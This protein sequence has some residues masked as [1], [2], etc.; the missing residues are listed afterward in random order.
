M[1]SHRCKPCVNV[2]VEMKV[3]L[4]AWS[5][6][7]N[8]QNHSTLHTTRITHSAFAWRRKDEDVSD[9]CQGW[10]FSHVSDGIFGGQAGFKNWSVN[11]RQNWFLIDLLTYIRL[12]QQNCA[13]TSVVLLPFPIWSFLL[14]NIYNLNTPI[15]LITDRVNRQN[16]QI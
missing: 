16:I 15:T 11:S 3:G 9:F 14:I 2:C 13:N 10:F 1:Y 6:R 7:E 8:L 4:Q 12:H 5:I